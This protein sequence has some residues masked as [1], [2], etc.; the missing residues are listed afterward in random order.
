MNTTLRILHLEDSPEDAE[1]IRSQ[2]E[3]GGIDCR[4]TRVESRETFRHAL[5][6]HRF[7]LIISDFTLPSFD[8]N[9]ALEMARE[10]A[11]HVPFIFVSGTIGEEAAIQGLVNGATDYVLKHRLE[12]LV[13]AVRRA[14]KELQERRSR[15]EAEAALR[16]REESF[17]LLFADNPH[18]M[19]VYDLETFGFLE[20]NDAAITKYGYSRDEFL[21]MRIIQIRPPEDIPILEEDLRKERVSIDSTHDWRHRLKDG[22]I[23]HVDI[24]SHTLTFNG[25]KSVLV[26]AQDITKRREAEEKLQESREYLTQV[27]DCI[28]DPVFV[29]DDKHRYLYVNR[30]ECELAGA[31]RD[32]MIGKTSADLFSKEEADVFTAH[33]D[34]VLHD[35]KEDTNEEEI[36]DAQGRVRIMVTKKRLLS[37]KEGNRSIVGVMRD[38]TEW[39]RSQ[40]AL[41]ESEEK[42]RLISENVADLIAVLDLQGRRVYSSPS[43]RRV[44]GD[45]AELL[46]T[47]SFGEI[48]PEDRAKVKAIFDETVRTG[49]GQRSEYRFVTSSGRIHEIE[50]QGSVIRD[51]QGRI[52]NVLVVSRDVT[53]KNAL[54]QQFLRSQRLESLGTLASGIAH[55]LNNVLA[56]ILLGLEILRKSVPSES[57]QKTVKTLQRSAERGRDIIKQVLTFGRGILGERGL[58]QLRHIV[59]DT[60]SIMGETFPKSIEV[61]ESIPRDTWTIRGDAT[62][63]SQLLMNLCVNARDAME[64]GGTLRI[65]SVYLRG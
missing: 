9:S 53:E 35:G 17:R 24:T 15:M 4:I 18:P 5:D 57:G 32:Q 58:L 56:P 20:V 46:G 22:S 48:H 6:H 36:A 29:K 40:E 8:G 44:L 12:R 23:I 47:D 28:A 27:I 64:E 49:V 19:W 11:T 31:T 45:P 39:K 21:G 13:P 51:K 60:I 7:D 63:L 2:L 34:L 38:M 33:D 43:Y 41:R 50:S 42:F 55:D 54:E 37:D 16:A 30:A 61:K 25:R 1:L 65:G 10:N 3:A 26:V 14:I 59:K 62:Q 52:T